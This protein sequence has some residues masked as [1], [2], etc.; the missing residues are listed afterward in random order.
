MPPISLGLGLG[1][2]RAS[3]P[4]P[5]L[6]DLRPAVSSLG[7][8]VDTVAPAGC[9][10]TRA[11]SPGT[12]Q[13]GASGLYDLTLFAGVANLLV[14]GRASDSWDVGLLLGEA[15]T[16]EVLA[17]RNFSAGS[18]VTAGT[19]TRTTG[20]SDAFGGTGATR[21]Q[22]SSG[23]HVLAET[24]TGTLSALTASAWVKGVAP[25]FNVFRSTT[26]VVAATT[27]GSVGAWGRVS[28]AHN[29]LG[30]ASSVEPVDGRDWSGVGGLVAG[31]RDVMLDACQ[32]EAGGYPDEFI[33]TAGAAATRA[34]SFLSLPG[35]MLA[36]RLI[37]GRVGI[38]RHVR[39]KGARSEYSGTRYL[40]WLD[41]NNHVSFA[42][43]TGVV[44]V[45]IAG[46]TN[47]T[48]ALT[49][50]R[51]S[52]GQVFVEMGAGVSYV[53]ILIDGVRTVPS[54]AGSALGS[55][56]AGD[57]YVGSSNVGGHSC[58]WNYFAGFYA[59]GT[60]PSWAW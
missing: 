47:T 34:A 32:R 56:S 2:S 28:V 57:L 14:S 8:A 35:A 48:S 27:A 42:P 10:Y 43:A 15:R 49:W 24:G 21:V 23:V 58:A 33:P 16:N 22:V 11:A 12:V 51:H 17:G 3:R 53:A 13:L 54:V 5:L 50:S 29:A 4:G 6:I 36:S 18:W 31:A 38:L 44:T 41:A 55:L 60:R 26:P 9:T 1:L 25:N 37:G 46:A 59:P 19:V 39:F 40:W 52:E 30:G 45:T 20:Q 7:W